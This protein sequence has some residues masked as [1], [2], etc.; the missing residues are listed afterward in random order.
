MFTLTIKTRPDF[1]ENKSS[2]EFVKFNNLSNACAAAYE[3]TRWEGTQSV[4]VHD[5]T[6]TVVY[7]NTGSFA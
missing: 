1:S 7:E 2:I 6:G 5:N 3:E 4:T